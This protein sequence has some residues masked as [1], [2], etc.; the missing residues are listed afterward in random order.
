ML[1]YSVCDRGWFGRLASRQRRPLEVV[2][3]ATAVVLAVALGIARPGITLAAEAGAPSG[4]ES[5]ATSAPAAGEQGPTATAP[6][7]RTSPLPE[8]AQSPARQ[9]LPAA[10]T[11]EGMPQPA[12]DADRLKP[13]G[14]DFFAAAPA[15]FTVAPDVPIPAGYRLG[16]HDKLRIR[17]WAPAV[18]EVTHETEVGEDGMVVVPG[19][20]D[21]SAHGITREEFRQRLGKRLR[22]QLKN[23]SFSADLIETRTISVFVT[24]AARRP[25]RYTV[26]AESNLFNVIYAAGGASPEGTLRKVAL[27]RRNKLVA[28]VDLYQFL[29]SG[30]LNAEVMLE[31]QD[32]V[33]FPIAGARV[34]VGGEVVRPAIYEVMPGDRVADAIRLAGGMKAS[35]Y[36]RILRFRRFEGG[37]RVERTLDAHAL[38]A[39][40]THAD[41]MLLRDGDILT[42][43]NVTRQVRERVSIRGNVSFAGDYSLQRTPTAKALLLEARPRIGTYWERADLTR[44]LPD[45]T[46]VIIP[47]PLKDLLDGKAEDVPLLDLDEIV[48]YEADE[49]KIVPLA[50]VEGA[51]KHPATYRVGDGMRVS[52]LLFAAGGVLQDA[53]KRV[54]HLYRRIGPNEFQIVRLAPEAALNGDPAENPVMQDGDRLVIYRQQDVE[55]RFDKVTVVGE[56]QHPGEY[57][58]YEGLTLYDLL[59]LAGGPTP[60]AAGIVEVAAPVLDEDSKKRTKIET[61]ALADVMSGKQEPVPIEPGMMISLPRRDDKLTQPCRVELRGRFRRPG[62]YAL[63]YEGE[64]LESLM[65][66][67]GGF[68]DDADPFG[69]SLTRTREKML[70][71][72]T[73]EQIRTVMETMDQLLPTRKGTTDGTNVEV[74]ETQSGSGVPLLG[75]AN[76]TEKVLLVSPRQL[77]GM[78]NNTRISFHLEDRESYVSRLGKVRLCDG[79]VIE[80]PR[81]SDV[82]QVLG[83]V[84]SPGPVF[85]NAGRS[86]REYINLAGGS[87]PDADL[88]RSVVIK[89]TGGVRRLAD[90]KT[91]DPGDV[92]VV[93]SKHQIIQPPVQRKLQDTILDLLGVALV[94]RSLQ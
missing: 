92:I 13:Y 56:L 12:A 57:R 79:D 10:P 82:V 30:T 55:F 46:P 84:Q 85:H 2:A 53:S 74:L 7:P 35:A 41:N 94:I 75:G 16:K 29:N 51:V 19:I 58:S 72:A 77:T 40:E 34:V 44:C 17:Y 23:V 3:L 28:E 26:K 11:S 18:P 59:L 24:G 31:D 64:D 67:A 73:S 70:S 32:V 80:V 21:V 89:V 25:G 4:A 47:L 69:M 87:A 15:D 36:A 81:R 54:A 76:R 66:R 62:T 49:K 45:G 90:S 8:N 83:A 86:A 71:L 60:Q 9:W 1:S 68:A 20:G 38:L 65:K 39:D 22:E 78:P 14:M 48:V 91:V 93:A 50:T 52:D 27:R 63:L 88:K 61:Y 37:R 42:L 33:F 6:A 5:P 43:E